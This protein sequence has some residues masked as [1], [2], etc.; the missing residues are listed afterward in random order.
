MRQ[1]GR[2]ISILLE[3]QERNSFEYEDL[4]AFHA[5]SECYCDVARGQARRFRQ[6]RRR[7]CHAAGVKNI[8]QL[9]REVKKV[10]PTWDRY[11]HFRLGIDCL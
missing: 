8:R 3:E 5:P 6:V 2:A 7:A 10:C 11:N 1:L 4:R 9:R